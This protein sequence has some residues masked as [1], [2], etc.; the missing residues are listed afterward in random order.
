MTGGRKGGGHPWAGV[1]AMLDVF[2]LPRNSPLLADRQGGYLSQQQP[3]G[4]GERVSLPLSR[5]NGELGK[6][7]TSPQREKKEGP[8]PSRRRTRMKAPFCAPTGKRSSP[9]IKEARAL[10]HWPEKRGKATAA[11]KVWRKDM[12]LMARKKG[13]EKKGRR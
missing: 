8:V 10:L 13:G 6:V 7:F 2:R 12:L 5:R 1:G 3:G 11:G 4:G 9:F